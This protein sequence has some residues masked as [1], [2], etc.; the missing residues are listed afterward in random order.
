M[1]TTVGI[2]RS[3]RGTPRLAGFSCRP[4]FIAGIN[5]GSG[6]ETTPWV[7][8]LC[9]LC[10]IK[11]KFNWFALALHL[12]QQG[13]GAWHVII[14]D[15]WLWPGYV[16]LQRKSHPF[17]GQTHLTEKS[18]CEYYRTTRRASF[19]ISGVSAGVSMSNTNALKL[20]RLFPHFAQSI[21]K[22]I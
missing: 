13:A 7:L 16:R 4:H 1:Q 8:G 2:N 10:G 15:G 19:A 21:A 12:A 6:T 22:F 5:D 17:L 3:C 14:M 18:F 20:T 9:V 11:W